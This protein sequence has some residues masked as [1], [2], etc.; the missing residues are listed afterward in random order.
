MIIRCQGSIYQHQKV[1][2]LAIM[3]IIRFEWAAEPRYGIL[4]GDT[5]HTLDG[6]LLGEFEAG[7][8]LCALSEVKLLA[9]IEPRTVACLA[10]NYHG[11]CK[12]MEREV[13]SAPQVFTKPASAV[14]GPNSDIIYPDVSKH[15]SCGGELAVVMRRDARD[16]PEE[17]ALE[18]VLGYTCANDVTALDL[19]EDRFETTRA[20]GYYTFCP[21]GPYIAT[22]V[23]SDNLTLK[24]R[25]NGKSF[26]DHS[27]N[28]MIWGVRQTVSYIS[29]FMALAPFDV[30]L[31]G[32]PRPEKTIYVGDEV[33]V[34]IEGIGILTNRVVRAGRSEA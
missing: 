9:P 11:L 10:P 8:A 29:Q 20:K 28:D 16:V 26:L 31:M 6:D 23:D 1:Q 13:P 27:T 18:F 21:L 30:I 22:G 32:T 4:E 24:S 5:V 3:K 2:A 12:E 14:T 34:E 19:L 33:E 15:V 25:F 7:V 17:K